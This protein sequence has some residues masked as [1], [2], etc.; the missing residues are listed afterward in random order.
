MRWLNKMLVVAVLVA[1]GFA[2]SAEP[3]VT[4]KFPLKV[5]LKHPRTL[6][7]Q[8][9]AKWVEKYSNGKIK[10]EVYPGSQLYKTK[11]GL[12]A[13]TMGGVEMMNPPNGHL[14]AYSKLFDLIELPFIFN[15]PQDFWNFLYS[16]IGW[17]IIKSAE[18]SNIVGL[19]AMDEGPMVIAAKDHFVKSPKDFKG[20]KIRTSGH[21]IVEDAIRT[22]GGST[23]RL[24]L[25]EV[26]TAAQQGVING[27]YTTF[28]AYMK[29]HLYEV[30][31]YVT[32]FPNHGAYVWVAS[33]QWW[34]KLPPYY[35]YIIE[36]AA[37]SAAAEYDVEIWSN[38]DNY[39]Q[40]LKSHGGHYYRPTPKDLKAME[41]AFSPN[42]KKYKA[43]YGPIF[44][45]VLKAAKGK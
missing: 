2:Y 39:I 43:K 21:P 9:F 24:P 10:V 16:D 41:K 6:K 32:L 17:K 12:Q 35:K 31:P 38:L 11:E 44:D 45:D 40:Q 29:K 30:L 25:G 36:T 34:D 14:V 27:V 33:K 42:W 26:Y 1:F 23:V 28:S 22:F 15:T 7:T 37:K 8:E 3:E 5:S 18:K 19:T 4:I 13:L 20:M